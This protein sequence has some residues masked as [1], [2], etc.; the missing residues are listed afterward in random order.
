MLDLVDAAALG[1]IPIGLAKA[2][3]QTGSRA[4][5]NKLRGNDPKGSLPDAPTD[6]SRRDFLKKSSILGAG[7]AAATSLGPLASTAL[8]K[9]STKAAAPVAKA[10]TA[11]FGNMAPSYASGAARLFLGWMAP[12]GMKIT[13]ELVKEIASKADSKGLATANKLFKKQA[14]QLGLKPEAINYEGIA[15]RQLTGEYPG[16]AEY[17]NPLDSNWLTD[18]QRKLAGEADDWLREGRTK[19]GKPIPNRYHEWILTGKPAPNPPEGLKYVDFQVLA[20]DGLGEMGHWITGDIDGPIQ[21]AIEALP[22]YK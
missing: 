9:F 6:M 8:R 2:G 3:L 15:Q 18:S 1:S 21:F 20:E 14:D 11:S 4:M 5:A 13:D 12:K 22:G 19:D 10:A 16:I 17:N 7:A